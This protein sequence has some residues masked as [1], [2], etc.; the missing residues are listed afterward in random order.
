MG[1]IK[2]NVQGRFH[3][4]A[5]CS[6]LRQTDDRGNSHTSDSNCASALRH[7]L[8]YVHAQ[9][10]HYSEMFENAAGRLFNEVSRMTVVSSTVHR[11]MIGI[12]AL[13]LPLRTCA[14]G[15]ILLEPV[16]C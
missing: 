3:E 13:M 9:R 14:A 15:K 8:C 2:A 10:P 6:P 5:C 1:L 12:T 11:Q 16:Y 7:N 4:W